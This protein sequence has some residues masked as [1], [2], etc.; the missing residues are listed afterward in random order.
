MSKS[1]PKNTTKTATSKKRGWKFWSAI[2]AVTLGIL[3]FLGQTFLENYAGPLLEY[4]FNRT[5]V[6][7][8]YGIPVK[9]DRNA[10]SNFAEANRF[11]AFSLSADDDINSNYFVVPFTLRNLSRHAVPE[12]RFRFAVGEAFAKLLDLK[13]TVKAPKFKT[14][15]FSHDL[16]V[17]PWEFPT[18]PIQLPV[19]WSPH[20]E[21]AEVMV[22]GSI[23]PERGFGRV[24]DNR[25]SDHGTF[26]PFAPTYRPNRYYL[27]AFAQNGW[28]IS[29]GTTPFPVANPTFM[30]GNVGLTAGTDP[31]SLKSSPPLAKGNASIQFE[32]GL[33]PHAE[34]NIFVLG[35]IADGEILRPT[36]QMDGLPGTGFISENEVPTL[37]IPMKEALN[38]VKVALM[39]KVVH[40]ESTMKGVVLIWDAS[41]VKGY[42]A[43]K[44]FK[45]SVRLLGDFSDPGMSI[46]YGKG[47]TRPFRIGRVL[48]QQKDQQSPNSE[49]YL[50]TAP[51]LPPEPKRPS[52]PRMLSASHMD[53]IENKYHFLDTANIGNEATYTLYVTN[54][55][56]IESYPVLITIPNEE[57]HRARD[58]QINE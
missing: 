44:I 55:S 29:E 17:T 57:V 24:K 5:T 40:A 32:N 7:V 20:I 22:Y 4:Y 15:P 50:E 16:P 33:D 37:S 26:V 35:K 6:S 30:C 42:S 2:G 52:A 14:I 56:G 46:F 1:R 31:K 58:Y 34:V 13:L 53:V 9:L 23:S 27:Q 8:R 54:E 11:E 38:P 10:L 45:S 18:L 47:E 51:R 39:P 36:V 41:D 19:V 21:E 12:V 25:L 48:A 49:K 3:T 28:G 43:V